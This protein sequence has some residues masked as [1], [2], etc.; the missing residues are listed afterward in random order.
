M[1]RDAGNQNY[2]PFPLKDL[3]ERSTDNLALQFYVPTFMLD[4][5]RWPESNAALY[6]ANKFHVTLPFARQRL[7]LYEDKFLQAS[8]DDY[9]MLV[10]EPPAAKYDLPECTD[11]AQRI[12]EKLKN[13]FEKKGEKFEIKSL[14]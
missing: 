2:L 4:Q 11:E 12:I 8:V 9:E 7:D 3:H 13:Q 5:L 6:V 10:R 14:L 1:L